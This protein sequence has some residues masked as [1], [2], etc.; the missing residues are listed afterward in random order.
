MIS[1]VKMTPPGTH[2][3][4][5]HK[6]RLT[7]MSGIRY[8]PAA[9]IL[10]S[11]AGLATENLSHYPIGVMFLLGAFQIWRDPRAL[12]RTRDARLLVIVFACVWLPMWL[13]LPDAANPARA[14]ET[15]LLYFH[16]LPA[17]LYVIHM[18]RDLVLRRIVLAG[19]AAIVAFW[20]VDGV[21]QLLTGRDLFGYPYDGSVLKGAFY[22]K[23]RFG[24]IL[25]VFTPLYIHVVH[26]AAARSV[27]AWLLLLP[28]VVVVIFS[29][30]RTAWI[31]FAVALSGY[32]ACFI[33]AT[34]ANVRAGAAAA[35]LV[36][37]TLAAT[38]YFAP[39]VHTQFSDTLKIFSADFGT[40]DV[41]TSYRL[42]LWQT[43]LAIARAHWLNGVGPRGYRTVYP[44]FAPTDDFWMAQGRKG[45]THPHLMVLEVLIETGVIGLGGYGA[46]LFLLVRRLWR[47][48]SRD[49]TAAA[50]LMVA[51]V[52]WFPLNAHLAFYGSYWSSIVWIMIALG[53]VSMQKTGDHLSPTDS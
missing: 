23:Q 1:Y 8:L 44:D 16:F 47:Q 52:A 28:L 38:I 10:L 20:C 17:G 12:L 35:V 39:K 11:I 48:R 53:C 49:P 7:T 2:R 32:G 50:Y 3:L 37:A 31:M 5:H 33:R 51:V 42:S 15:T 6:V 22:P 41:A 4:K 18:L 24:L 30:K 13:A 14:V 34:R 40:A 25:A 45:Q 43:G 26:R 19:L 27:W 29:L 46:C 9:L 21:I 36:A